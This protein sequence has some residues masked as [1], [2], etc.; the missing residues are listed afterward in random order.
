MKERSTVEKIVYI[1]YRIL[2]KGNHCLYQR[3]ADFSYEIFETKKRLR[4]F[5]FDAW[6]YEIWSNPT[7]TS[8]LFWDKN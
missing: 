8:E 1:F 4:Y 7:K 6:W 2:S 5:A 3:P